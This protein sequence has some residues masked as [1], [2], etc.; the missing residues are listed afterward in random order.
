MKKSLNLETINSLFV[1]VDDIESN[2]KTIKEKAT[3][4]RNLQEKLEKKKGMFSDFR[5]IK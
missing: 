2:V 1:V 3:N 4:I 5:N